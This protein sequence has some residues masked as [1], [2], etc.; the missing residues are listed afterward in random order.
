M[1]I[2]GWLFEQVP[3]LASLMGSEVLLGLLFLALTATL[4]AFGV[5]GVILPISF[6]SGAMLGGWLGMLV[7]VLGAVAGSHAF[8]LA[9]RHWLA[10]RVRKRWGSRIAR[11][12]GEISRRGFYY[13]L[14]LR[15]V[16]VPHLPVTA[17]SALSSIRSRSFALAT[18]L[19]FLP[20][21]TI[22]AMAGSAV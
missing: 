22:A 4:V 8:F 9:A 15:L 7:V 14:G 21:I 17:A 18:T 11:F 10:E 5:P 16:G 19:G 20:A 1:D 2:V 6:S 12:D 13:L 3:F